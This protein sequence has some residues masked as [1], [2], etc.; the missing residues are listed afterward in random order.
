M[1]EVVGGGFL[2][3]QTTR[4]LWME[5]VISNHF[6][7][8]DLVHHPIETTI[9]KWLFGVPGLFIIGKVDEGGSSQFRDDVSRA[10]VILFVP[11]RRHAY[12]DC[13]NPPRGSICGCF[14]K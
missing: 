6:P 4:F 3:L 7:C 14:Q 9:Y 8:K 1:D 11:T 5:M 13:S 12:R 2:E 10:I